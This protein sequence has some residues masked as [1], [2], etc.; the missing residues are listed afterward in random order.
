M[1]VFVVQH[2]TGYIAEIFST[3]KFALGYVSRHRAEELEIIAREVDR[4]SLGNEQYRD[5]SSDRK[6]K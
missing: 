4:V 5:S 6:G 3:E 2:M 1:I